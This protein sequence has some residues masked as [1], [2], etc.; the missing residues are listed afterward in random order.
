MYFSDSLLWSF[1]GPYAVVLGASYE[2]MGLIRSS[3][4]LFQ[5]LLQVFWG[6]VSERFGK[7]FL[8]A[9]GY[10][11]SGFFSMTFVFLRDPSQLIILVIAQSVLWSVAAPAWGSLLAD[12]TTAENRGEVLG[13]VGAVSQLSGVIAAFFVAAITCN[14]PEKMTVSSFWIPLGLAASSAFL[15]AILVFFVKEAKR[16]KSRWAIRKRILSPL[17]NRDFRTFLIIMGLNWFSMAFAW[18]LFPYVTINVVHATVWQIA[19]IS[20]L[21]GLL[22]TITQ[23]KF[24][25][26]VDRVGRRPFLILGRA[27]LT[28][29]PLLY[30]FAESW[31]HLLAIHMFLAFPTSSLM[32][33]FSAYI[34]DSAP[35][36][37]RANYIAIVNFVLGLSTFTGS[38]AGGVYTGYLSNVKGIVN[39]LFWG[40]IT[41]AALRIISSFGLFFIKETKK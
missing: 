40:L 3:R 32:V 21:P 30:A 1:L 14:Q 38:L 13:K 28:L 22:I 39:P 9:L 37:L 7:R 27:S 17:K 10:F 18:P 15:S 20:A 35:P 4:N 41:S 31:L 6:E 25:S 29:Y 2:Q 24:G 12:Y 11:S 5:N 36:G 8:I 16:T 33:S 23:P 26:L 19:L 34:M